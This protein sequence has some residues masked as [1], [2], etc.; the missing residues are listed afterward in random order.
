MK[1][2]YI[3][4]WDMQVDE[5]TGKKK[6]R[7][8]NGSKRGKYEKIYQKKIIYCSFDVFIILKI[9]EQFVRKK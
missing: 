7:L 3:T 4:N 9:C 6:N 5:K 1:A 8:L 2:K